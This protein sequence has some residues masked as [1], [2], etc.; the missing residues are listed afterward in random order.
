MS[1]VAVACDD[2]CVISFSEVL[3]LFL[4]KGENLSVYSMDDDSNVVID[5]DLLITSEGKDI[6]VEDWISKS[7]IEF[8]HRLVIQYREKEILAWT[9]LS[10]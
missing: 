9:K 10:G 4:T 3:T 8:N 1:I 6:A 2:K 5:C 7:N